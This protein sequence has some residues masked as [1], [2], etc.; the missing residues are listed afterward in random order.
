MTLFA[1]LTDCVIA[2]ST[3]SRS[4]GGV[5]AFGDVSVALANCT[6]QANRATVGGGALTAAV[7]AAVSIVSGALVDNFA[8]RIVA[9][10]LEADADNAGY[11]GA[12]WVGSTSTVSIRGAVLSRNEAEQSGGSAAVQGSG[13]VLRISSCTL[14]ASAA[15][16]DGGVFAVSGASALAVADSSIS[17]ASAFLGGF[18][19]FR[20]GAAQSA[21]LTLLRVAL[22]NVT[23]SAGA[24]Y[25]TADSYL[26]FQAPQCVDCPPCSDCASH[27]FGQEV[28]TL[29]YDAAVDEMN[30]TRSGSVLSVRLTLRDGFGSQ[31]SV[32]EQLPIIDQAVSD[33]SVSERVD[34][35]RRLSLSHTCYSSC[36][37]ESFWTLSRR[38]NAG[39]PSSPVEPAE[40]TAA[41]SLRCSGPCGR[42]TRAPAPLTPCTAPLCLRCVVSHPRL[43]LPPVSLPIPAIA[44]LS[45]ER[46]CA[47][48]PAA[49]LRPSARRFH[50]AGV[51]P[52]RPRHHA[53]ELHRAR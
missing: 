41:R 42:P 31:A 52:A 19:S 25:A 22:A 33:C 10:V 45:Q 28:A 21:N 18:V 11:G 34:S 12:V 5:A 6:F 23:A 39:P 24:I 26:P 53:R 49:P 36:R 37:S 32:Q 40:L 15:I 46:L 20:Q 29:P 44:T 13:A 43:T 8:G 35:A 47:L 27:S 30:A 14:S 7:G 17:D 9:S 1:S 4:G 50:A 38:L 48:L 2:G 16:V 51:R 3:C